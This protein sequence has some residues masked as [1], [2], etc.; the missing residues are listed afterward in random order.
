MAI[1]KPTGRQYPLVAKVDFTFADFVSGVAAEAVK[2]PGN[3]RVSGG[4][5][6]IS[7]AFNSGTSD[8]I[9]VG[10]G[11]SAA[12]YKDSINGQAVA[13]TALVPTGYKYTVPDTIDITWTGVGAAPTAGAGYLMVEYFAENRA[14]EVV[15][16]SVS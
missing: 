12:R 16:N 14:N 4:H 8:T 10:D 6:V 1:T 5:L 3:C 15:P 2:I 13:L 7:T 11:D 9:Q